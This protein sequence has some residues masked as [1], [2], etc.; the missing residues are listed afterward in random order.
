MANEY[1]YTKVPRSSAQ[2]TMMRGITDFT[3]AQQFNLYEKGHGFL[4]VL[5]TPKFMTQLPYDKQLTKLFTYILEYEF[6][7]LDGIEDTTIENIEIT[8]GIN[9]M[10]TAG[11]ST[12]NHNVEWSMTFTEKSGGVINKFL[13]RY[14][15]GVKDPNSQAKTYNGLIG[16]GTLAA[17]LENEVFQ[18]MYIVTDNT[19]LMLEKAYILANAYPTK[20]WDSMYN[21]QKGEI[22]KHESDITF[23]GFLVDGDEVDKKA[24]KILSYIN[25]SGHVY[26]A[27]DRFTKDVVEEG[28][29]TA[30]V[31][32]QTSHILQSGSSKFAMHNDSN[33]FKYSIV[34]SSNK[35][36][37]PDGKTKADSYVEGGSGSSKL[38]LG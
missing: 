8:D 14:I 32:D 11:K 24:I 31:K 18:L 27:Y 9:T 28:A 35:D 10:N 23:T 30:T 37:N 25:Q 1:G 16:D 21:G 36:I 13:N 15:R 3:N 5:D 6:R 19:H 12:M 7:G 20:T 4:V 17:G 26:N 33:Q 29:F 38:Y 34:D 2:Y 22:D